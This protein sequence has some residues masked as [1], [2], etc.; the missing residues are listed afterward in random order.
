MSET[1]VTEY[2]CTECG[3]GETGYCIYLTSYLND[4]PTD[5]PYHEIETQAKWRESDE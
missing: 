3:E 1:H 4:P 2:I 5:C